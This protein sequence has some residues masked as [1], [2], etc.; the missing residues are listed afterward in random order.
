MLVLLWLFLTTSAAASFSQVIQDAGNV[1]AALSRVTQG[2]ACFDTIQEDLNEISSRSASPGGAQV[3]REFA[4]AARVR[5]EAALNAT[6]KLRGALQT[7]PQQGSDFGAECCSVRNESP[8]TSCFSAPFRAPSKD[9]AAS[10]LAL[11][12]LMN[13]LL[14]SNPELASLRVASR[15]SGIVRQAPAQW[16]QGAS[17]SSD[18]RFEPYW[19]IAMNEPRNFILLIDQS[20]SNL[21]LS[22][23]VV[24][25]ILDSLTHQDWVYVGASSAL[26]ESCFSSSLSQLN[27]Y[28]R[29][30][31]D[32]YVNSLLLVPNTASTSVQYRP[33]LGQIPSI[34]TAQ[35][36]TAAVKTVAVLIGS[37]FAQDG[38]FDAQI[39]SL[40]AS[41]D[42]VLFS[43]AIGVAETLP[44]FALMDSIA[45]DGQT[46]SAISVLKN[47]AALSNHLIPLINSAAFQ[48]PSSSACFATRPMFDETELFVTFSCPLADG[49][50]MAISK[51]SLLQIL[52]QNGR[53]E[54]LGGFSIIVDDIGRVYQHPK[55][56]APQDLGHE[57][58]VINLKELERENPVFLAAVL[59]DLLAGVPGGPIVGPYVFSRP[60]GGQGGVAS[61]SD[62]VSVAY[63]WSDIPGTD[64]RIC[65]VLPVAPSTLF[66]TAQWPL[67][68][69]HRVDVDPQG[70]PIMFDP[71]RGGFP[72]NAQPCCIPEDGGE[73]TCFEFP[74]ASKLP[75]D[76][77]LDSYQDRGQPDTVA[78][79]NDYRRWVEQPYNKSVSSFGDALHEPELL[80]NHIQASRVASLC[81]ERIKDPIRDLPLFRYI[82]TNSGVFLNS[83]SGRLVSRY[84]PRVRGWYQQAR[85]DVQSPKLTLTAPYVDAFTNDLIQTLSKPLIVG[86]KASK[87]LFGVTGVDFYLSGIRKLFNDAVT[88]PSGSRCF[89]IDRGG[90][91]LLDPLDD[92][93]LQTPEPLFF[94]DRN[95][96]LAALEEALVARKVMIRSQCI[97]YNSI[98][99]ETFYSLRSLTTAVSGEFLCGRGSF[100][101][102]PVPNA[103]FF[104]VVVSNVEQVCQSSPNDGICMSPCL[105]PLKLESPCS[106]SFLP[107]L[108]LRS[109]PACPGDAVILPLNSFEGGLSTGN[110]SIDSFQ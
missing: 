57:P 3:V 32:E 40:V 18:A 89:L 86:G 65:V 5:V 60:R 100:V 28:T 50:A 4:E 62:P 24:R 44:Q 70:Q 23:Q 78:F 13:D 45:R 20:S 2:A 11:E 33:L 101:V 69:Y 55:V 66:P 97:N 41:G 53:A 80:H 37:G 16:P 49:S 103:T 54:T 73:C 22:K 30:Q 79:I 99:V 42:T 104:L 74:P 51:I 26:A 10:S 15:S 95:S 84:D 102:A 82:G 75:P 68:I 36:G 94:G 12:P 67:H 21:A 81:W 110:F 71:F 93:A 87:T 91:L 59:P 56:P 58:Y 96:E 90:F 85:L 72:T 63:T 61:A 1:Y 7:L 77:F 38:P 107:V 25:I 98:N 108:T 31:I 14:Q 35:N 88:C 105:Q 109:L 8:P 19:Q 76:A 48:R 47:D 43:V 64:F 46:S 106:G 29:E 39:N 27:E 9:F 6:K 17:C 34:L 83:P 52:T 92:N